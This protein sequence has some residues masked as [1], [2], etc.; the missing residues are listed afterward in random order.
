MQNAKMVSKDATFLQYHSTEAVV[1]SPKQTYTGKLD[2]YT[3]I[4]IIICPIATA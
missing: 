3:Y 1:H 2:M 4:I